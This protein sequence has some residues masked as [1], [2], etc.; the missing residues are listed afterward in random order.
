MRF[1]LACAKALTATA[2]FFCF[3][4]GGMAH[5]D[6][7][8]RGDSPR[9]ALVPYQPAPPPPSYLLS[10]SAEIGRGPSSV[11]PSGSW[12]GYQLMLADAVSIGLGIAAESGE[13]L[14]AGYFVAPIILHGMHRRPVL[15]V[16]SPI[17]RF[18]FPLI[19]MTLGSTVRNCNQHGD[20]CALGGMIY[21][22]GIGV[23]AAMILDWSLA[24]SAPAT[25]APTPR[26][27]ALEES[28]EPSPVK[29]SSLAI[30]TAGFAPNSKGVSFVLGGQF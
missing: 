29:S 20:E 24:W 11:A 17:T 15:A 10:P 19:G 14:L 16:V 12:Y 26:A 21:G 23:A 1:L 30:T 28:R 2:V 5:A 18:L 7:A 9:P 8:P 22:A 25:L 4:T 6:A 13:V 3:S 27:Y